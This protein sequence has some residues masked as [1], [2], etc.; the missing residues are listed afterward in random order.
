MYI[1]TLSDRQVV[2]KLCSCIYIVWTQANIDPLPYA[3]T[4]ISHGS[5]LKTLC[6]RPGVL[7]THQ[8]K[9][10]RNPTCNT[11]AHCFWLWLPS[12]N[13]RIRCCMH[14]PVL[15]QV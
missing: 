1:A 8:R 3:C 14:V 11:W 15:Y 12:S 10:D 13:A 9:P 7:G 2:Q 5:Q 4:R 6:V